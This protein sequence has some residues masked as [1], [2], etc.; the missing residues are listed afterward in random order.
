MYWR[1]A[2]E[3]VYE[4]TKGID[5]YIYHFLKTGN[6]HHTLWHIKKKA[7]QRQ[8]SYWWYVAFTNEGGEGTKSTNSWLYYFL[9]TGKNGVGDNKEPTDRYVIYWYQVIFGGKKGLGEERAQIQA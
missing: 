2:E 4:K 7:K 9:M 8:A 1:S 3:E 6:I 5:A